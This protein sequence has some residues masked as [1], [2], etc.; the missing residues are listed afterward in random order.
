MRIEFRQKPHRGG[1]AGGGRSGRSYINSHAMRRPS[2]R[3]VASD[4]RH[5]RDAARREVEAAIRR[6]EASDLGAYIVFDAE[7]ARRQADAVDRT[8]SLGEDP[9]PLAGITV[10]VK[11]LY[12]LDGY[13][14]RAGTKRPLPA[15]PEGFLVR[16]LRRLGAVITGK[17]HTVE[18]AF[19]AVGLNPNTGT[20]VNPWDP[21]EHRA[22]GGSSAGAGVSL[23]E[24]SA[25]IAL[26]SDTGGSIRIPASATGVVGFRPTT[27]R[28]PT[29]G[30]VPLSTTLDTVGLLTHTVEDLRYAFRAIDPLAGGDREGADS[31]PEGVSGLRIGVPASRLW[32]DA[33]SG[34][35]AV[36]ERAVA[37]LGEAGATVLEIDLPELDE[38]GERYFAGEIVQPEFLEFLE[39]EL[40]EW[41]PLLHAIVGKRLGAAGK[42]RALDYVAALQQ[43]RRLSASV[44]AR[45]ASERIDCLATPTLPIAP[46]PLAVLARLAAYRDANRAML[47]GTCPASMLDL[48]AITLPAGLDDE[49]MPVGLQLMGPAGGDLALLAQAAAVEPVLG[50]NLSRLGTPP[51]LSDRYD[52][53]PEAR[54]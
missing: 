49:G 41:I 30:V 53:G 18:F 26:G 17:T 11:D 31:A 21:V 5:G 45:M 29:T 46:P 13:P 24:G 3:Q 22:P 4:V 19:G 35:V 15:W 27:G 16:A 32:T 51:R 38:A 47:S 43:R 52:S 7:A 42:V 9:G 48:C 14:L 36:V 10:S 44:H 25:R 33:D 40:P 34:I 20:P 50:T 12:A 54:G 6:H 28:W 23:W 37:E 39:R 8:A 1:P 2:I